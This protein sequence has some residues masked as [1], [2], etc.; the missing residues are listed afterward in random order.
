MC[1]QFSTSA[2]TLRIFCSL[3]FCASSLKF[4]PLTQ[5]CQLQV[6]QLSPNYAAYVNVPAESM[7]AR[8]KSCRLLVFTGFTGQLMLCILESKTTNSSP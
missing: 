3:S 5:V 7:L 4:L 2:G 6:C 8:S 1:T